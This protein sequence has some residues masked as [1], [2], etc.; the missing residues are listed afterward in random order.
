MRGERVT[1]ETPI[2]VGR[3]PG[4]SPIYEWVAG[5]VEDVL[6]APGPREDVTDSTRPDGVRVRYTL[7]FP[8]PYDTDL[9]GARISVRGEEPLAVVGSPRPYT[10]AN[11]PTR[12]W[13]PV[14]VGRVD[15]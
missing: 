1:V 9:T 8:K 12:W 10:L 11:T 6:V 14:E 15:G 7:H 5:A 4:N 13:M 2:E 3:G